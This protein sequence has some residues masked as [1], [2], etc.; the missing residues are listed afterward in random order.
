MKG[1]D[2]E[3]VWKDDIETV[4]ATIGLRDVDTPNA[5]GVRPLQIACLKAYPDREI[6]SYLLGMG[7]SVDFQVGPG[8]SFVDA[9]RA[10]ASRNPPQESALELVEKVALK[11]RLEQRLT[12]NAGVHAEER[13]RQSSPGKI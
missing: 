11:N 3:A 13:A 10:S 12:G 8:L 9:L 5:H 1:K 2:M 6:V 4:R 7:A